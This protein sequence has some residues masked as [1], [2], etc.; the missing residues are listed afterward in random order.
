MQELYFQI[1]ELEQQ[2]SAQGDLIFCSEVHR[3]IQE[4]ICA[5]QEI[6]EAAGI[7]DP[8]IN[9]DTYPF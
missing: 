5:F 4:A 2:F 7:D 8:T 6:F 1:L 3:L 9:Q